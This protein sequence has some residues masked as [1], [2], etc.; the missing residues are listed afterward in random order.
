MAFHMLHGLALDLPLIAYWR[1]RIPRSLTSNYCSLEQNCHH[2]LFGVRGK[3]NMFRRFNWVLPWTFFL[4]GGL[5]FLVGPAIYAAQL[6][7]S[8]LATPWF[9]PILATLGVF[10]MAV[11]ASQRRGLLRKTGL[12]VAALLCTFEWFMILVVFSTPSYSGPA[13]V[14]RRLPSFATTLA[15]GTRFTE[16]DLENGSP[17]VLLFIRGRW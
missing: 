4:F 14:G 10:C 8:R 9:V 15:D 6:S 17:T 5:L 11:S 12:V 7:R 2:F 3:A 13:Q 1:D 16:K